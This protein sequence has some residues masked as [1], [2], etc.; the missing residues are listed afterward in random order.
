MKESK[1]GYRVKLLAGKV[2]G[3]STA[4]DYGGPMGA[5]MPNKDNKN[6]I[7]FDEMHEY[8]DDDKFNTVRNAHKV[9]R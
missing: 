9:R 8:I 1:Y 3:S 4:T 2:T 7:I 6:F 5:S